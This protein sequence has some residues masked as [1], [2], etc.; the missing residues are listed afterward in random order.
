VTSLAV[1]ISP[2]MDTSTP[3]SELIRRRARFTGLCELPHGC[4]GAIGGR[5]IGDDVGLGRTSSDI[6][7]LRGEVYAAYRPPKRGIFMAV[8]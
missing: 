7:P 5:A 8:G 1:V 3:P 6:I 2:R 4:R